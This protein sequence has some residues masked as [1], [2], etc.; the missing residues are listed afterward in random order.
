M[1]Y[2]FLADVATIK[3]FNAS[4]NKCFLP[5][6]ASPHIAPAVL[7]HSHLAHVLHRHAGNERA[8]VYLQ[9]VQ[10]LG[11]H[12]TIGK[13]VPSYIFIRRAPDAVDRNLSCVVAA[14][15]STVARVV[16]R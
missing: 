10:E 4:G 11:E 16:A 5:D 2:T 15:T 9:Q 7:S 6:Y 14:D 3:P 1:K 8:N 13:G 12:R